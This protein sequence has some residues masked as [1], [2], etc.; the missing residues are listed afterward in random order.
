MKKP[1][2]IYDGECPFC[3]RLVRLLAG[4]TKHRLELLPASVAAARFPGI[5]Q[6]SYQAS[7][8]WVAADGAVSEGALALF[9][10]LGSRRGFYRAGLWLY[11]RAP[12]F[13]RLSESLYALVARNRMRLCR[14]ETPRA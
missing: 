4:I 9:L 3:R 2:L 8:Q 14:A 11:R 5:P 10:A 13:A 12:G 7:M 6:E 1:V